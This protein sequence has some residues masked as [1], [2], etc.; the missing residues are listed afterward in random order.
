VGLSN[1]SPNEWILF[2]GKNGSIR[3]NI[4]AIKNLKG[5]PARKKNEKSPFK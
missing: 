2:P 5:E 3:N 1:N 4:C